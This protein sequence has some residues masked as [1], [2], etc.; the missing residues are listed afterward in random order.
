MGIEPSQE[1]PLVADTEGSVR[2]LVNGDGT[3]DEVQTGGCRTELKDQVSEGHGVVVSHDAIVLDGEQKREIHA[4]GNRRESA[5]ALGGRYREAAVE[6]GDEDV[7]E[8]AV[9]LGVSSD[10]VK[11]QLLR[12]PTLDG[13]ESAFASAP[14]LWG[15]STDV[16]GVSEISCS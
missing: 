5:L 3:A 6:V 16:P 11:P 14:S 9:G 15:A 13:A 7:L 8:I 10:A 1:L 2:E 4:F 12:E